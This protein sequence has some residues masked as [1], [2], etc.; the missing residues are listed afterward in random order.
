MQPPGC[1]GDVLGVGDFT[2]QTKVGGVQVNLLHDRYLTKKRS[3]PTAK[4]KAWG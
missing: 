3:K 1:L 2:Q 4:Q